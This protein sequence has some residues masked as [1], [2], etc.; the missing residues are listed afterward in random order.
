MWGAGRAG[1]AGTR[2]LH[3][4][5]ERL[6]ASANVLLASDIEA[7]SCDQAAD[8]APQWDDQVFPAAVID[9]ERT[10]A[11]NERKARKGDARLEAPVEHAGQGPR[12]QGQCE[13]DRQGLDEPPQGLQPCGQL[14]SCLI[15][16]CV[17]ACGGGASVRHGYVPFCEDGQWTFQ[18]SL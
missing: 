15:A 16:C 11:Q 17:A 10:A 6:G 5:P 8:Y 1:G 13:P 12:D 9:A 2:L 4:V 7:T 18:Q 3:V 14:L